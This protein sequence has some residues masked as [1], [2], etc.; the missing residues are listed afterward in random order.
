MLISAMRRP[1]RSSLLT[2]ALIPA[3]AIRFE[4]IA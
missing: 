4:D 2:V 3:A 1:I